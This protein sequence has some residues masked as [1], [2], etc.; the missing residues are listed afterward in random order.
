MEEP[1]GKLKRKMNINAQHIRR[2]KAMTIGNLKHN[3]LNKTLTFHRDMRDHQL[4]YI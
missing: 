4:I 1:G 2:N 3:L